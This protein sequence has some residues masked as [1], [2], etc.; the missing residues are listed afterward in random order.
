MSHSYARQ[1]FNSVGTDAGLPAIVRLYSSLVTLEL[2][3]KD[4]IAVDAGHW[5]SGHD[6]HTLMVTFD[7]GLA[8]LATN[9][10]TG[11]GTLYCTDKNGNPSLVSGQAY[12]HLRYLRH[13]TDGFGAPHSD[14]ATIEAVH[15][16]A[17]Q[18]I[19]QLQ[20][21]GLVP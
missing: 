10:R 9:L 17:L 19:Q 12:P 14:D 1:S 5:V 8:V 21:Q 3:L 4:A 20:Q 7:A 16:L 6:V 15:Q 18:C 2:M 13:S 11:I